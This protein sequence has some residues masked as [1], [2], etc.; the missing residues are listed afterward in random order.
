MLYYREIRQA[1]NRLVLGGAA[2][3]LQK[4]TPLVVPLERGGLRAVAVVTALQLQAQERVQMALRPSSRPARPL[5]ISLVDLLS[6]G[7]SNL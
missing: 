5:R 7:P 3:Q 2:A 4:W 1:L 6:R